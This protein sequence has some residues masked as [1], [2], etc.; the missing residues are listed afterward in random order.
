[1][2][3][4]VGVVNVVSVD[5]GIFNIGDVRII[6]PRI[7]EKTFAG[8]GSFNSG[9]N[10]KIDNSNTALNVYESSVVDQGIYMQN[11]LLS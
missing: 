11:D 9:T 3:A 4:I 7:S 6:S 1:M 8:G 5:R 10:L 2:P